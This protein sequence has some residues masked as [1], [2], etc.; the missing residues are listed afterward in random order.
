VKIKTIEAIAVR[1]PMKKPVQMAGETVAQAE[2]VFV[3]IESDAGAVGWGEAAAAPTMTG[4]TI[5]GMM[6]AIELMRPKLFGRAAYDFAGAAAAMDAQLY[7]NSGAKAAIDM[8]LHDLV[9]RASE[10]PVYALFGTK[11]RSRMP[12]LAVI[13][14]EDAAADLRDAQARWNAGYRAFKI[15]VGLGSPEADAVRTM[16]LCQ[17]LKG[18]ALKGQAL[19]GQAQAGEPCL[20][21]A[22]ANQGFSVEGAL[23]FVRGIGDC[24]L[25]FFEQPVSASDLDGM[26]R[27]AAATKVPIGA[28]EGIHSL[29]DI[30]RHHE[31]KAARGVSLKAIKLGGLSGL[32]AASR[33]CGQ[34]GMQV[35]ISCKTGETSLASAAAVHLAAVAPALAWGL[36]V[37]SSGLAEDVTAAPLHVDAGYVEVPERPGL[38]IDVDEHRLRRRQREFKRVA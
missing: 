2:N 31:R 5:A 29:D 24:G 9:G 15:K 19:E 6:A 23:T 27:I 13:G 36:T 10:R 11:Q 34:L 7:G 1:L 17:A 4:E 32:F 8:A 12:V 3:R 22:D 21:S 14:S 35:N 38:G 18:Q 25:D 33:L 20:V 16:M 26:S 37:T 28:D 30:A